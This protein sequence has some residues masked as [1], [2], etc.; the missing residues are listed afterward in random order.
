MPQAYEI[1]NP[2]NVVN[3]TED[4]YAIRSGNYAFV[5]ETAEETTTSP[6]PTHGVTQEDLDYI[7]NQNAIN[8]GVIEAPAETTT[9][10]PTTTET[11]EA[12]PVMSDEFESYQ[13]QTAETLQSIYGSI[14][15]FTDQVT[16]L[17]ENFLETRQTFLDSLGELGTDFTSQLVAL[18]QE[19][20]VQID[21]SNEDLQNEIQNAYQAG[22]SEEEIKAILSKA[23]Y[24][25]PSVSTQT[26]VPTKSVSEA[27]QSVLDQVTQAGTLSESLL[28]AATSA[29]DSGM[30]SEQQYSEYLSKFLP[31]STTAVVEQAAETTT[32]FDY[33]PPAEVSIL[34]ALSSYAN[35]DYSSMSATITAMLSDDQNLSE[36]SSAEVNQLLLAQISLDSSSAMYD[37]MMTTYSSMADRYKEV[38]DAAKENSSMVDAEIAAI[39]AGLI[40][41]ATE[42]TTSGGLM[43][44]VAE[45]TYGTGVD[46]IEAQQAYLDA[47]YEYTY[48]QMADQN[49]RL[50]SYMKAKLNAMGAETSSAGLTMM[51]TVIDNAQATLAMY[52]LSYTAESV[53]LEI[54][55]TE[56]MNTYYAAV[57]EQSLNADAAEAEALSTYYDKLDQIELS[58]IA[59]LQEMNTQ[60]LATI[61]DLTSSLYTIQND[62]MTWEYNL[63]NDA[64]NRALTESEIARD[65]ENEA[66]DNAFT[67]LEA[68]ISGYYGLTWDSIPSETKT[69]ILEY[70][71]LVGLPS[72]YASSQL[73]AY[74]RQLAASRSSSSGSKLDESLLQYYA[75]KLQDQSAGIID[76]PSSYREAAYNLANQPI[77]QSILPT[78]L[79]NLLS[80]LNIDVGSAMTSV[81]YPSIQFDV[82][83]SGYNLF[84]F[85]SDDSIFQNEAVQTE[86]SKS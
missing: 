79:S 78:G 75:S 77:V 51:S 17:N 22:A 34:E 2:D 42:V 58:E 21:T 56:L 24:Q 30:L 60:S 25:I 62:Q 85:M 38:Y 33:T 39:Q 66:K 71:S 73:D 55:K 23:E 41:S 6:S 69:Q 28:T 26:V 70:S 16:S 72:D 11:E 49:L 18:E 12:T 1:A 3:V 31:D 50:E 52:Q 36:M 83:T 53:Q 74:N 37:Q 14:Q 48:T 13:Q 10:E 4:S 82:N 57:Q 44:L 5:G 76:I 9:V 47:Q 80:M 15:G 46:S 35:L 20:G 7:Q 8:E 40:T 54:S 19:L 61:S 63:A 27:T 32:D 84:P 64:Y 65:I 67:N 59:S 29:Y 86:S 43:A 68:I 45:Q 81:T